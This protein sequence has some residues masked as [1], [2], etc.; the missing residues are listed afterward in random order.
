MAAPWWRAVL[1]GSRSWRGFSTSGE[2][3]WGL[4]ALGGPRPAEPWGSS[5][6]PL[7]ASA[8]AG[9]SLMSCS[10]PAAAVSRRAAPLGPMPNEDI[11]V[12]SLERLKKYRS[13]DR[14]RRRAER[15]ARDAHW[16]RTYREHF[17]EESGGGVRSWAV[18]PPPWD[19]EARGSGFRR[20]APGQHFF[21]PFGPPPW[22]I[23]F[24]LFDFHL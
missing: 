2:G 13:F 21:I 1:N 17:G 15:E 23:L 12:S 18:T 22:K 11:D 4:G 8:G 7:R 6:L 3:C 20:R 9:A 19:S 10:P 5:R 24:S 14:Y 16:W